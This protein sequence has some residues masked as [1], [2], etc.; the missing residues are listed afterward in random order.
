L[1]SYTSA[2]VQELQRGLASNVPTLSRICARHVRASNATPP[3]SGS[4]ELA[5][6]L[7]PPPD[8]S[9]TTVVL[10]RSVRVRSQFRAALE[11]QQ[12]A[13]RGEQLVYP[14]FKTTVAAE[15]RRADSVARLAWTDTTTRASAS[16]QRTP[17]AEE[18]QAYRHF[19]FH[20]AAA[21][22][23]LHMYP[24]DSWR[25]W[26]WAPHWQWQHPSA[27]QQ[28]P[29]QPRLSCPWVRCHNWSVARMV[30]TEVW[31]KPL[32]GDLQAMGRTFADTVH[33]VTPRCGA[34]SL[35]TELCII[36]R[37][38]TRRRRPRAQHLRRDHGR[39]CR[40]LRWCRPPGDACDRH[41]LEAHGLRIRLTAYYR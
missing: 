10:E 23:Q 18:A 5:C 28:Q 2:Q 15:R 12:R 25:G 26:A 41:P 1:W 29:L 34:C 39:R 19:P 22:W 37:S 31:P 35:S 17:Q 16:I 33:T 38:R 13:G 7:L 9:K 21:S 36:T 14:C 4:S 27:P 32:C 8:S 6:R 20:K 11:P 3:F 40:H 30:W 24:Q